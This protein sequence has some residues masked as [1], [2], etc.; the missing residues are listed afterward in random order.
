MKRKIVLATVLCLAL[1]AMLGVGASAA[2]AD[3]FWPGVSTAHLAHVWP[4][5]GH[6]WMGGAGWGDATDYPSG[7]PIPARDSVVIYVAGVWPVRADAEAMS[8]ALLLSVTV[9]APDGRVVVTTTEAESPR[10]WLP[11]KWYPAANGW[12]RGWEVYVGQL[13]AGTYRVAFVMHQPE[14]IV[15][16]DYDDDGN[17]VPTVAKAFRKTFR[18]S[19]SVQ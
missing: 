1:A 4:T 18:C 9:T 14:A 19:F 10:H 7:T 17:L 6:W 15:V 8:Q 13:P 3:P 11:V 16:S 12:W 2:A 5:D